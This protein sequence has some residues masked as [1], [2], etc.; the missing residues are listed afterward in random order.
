M[1]FVSNFNTLSFRLI[2]VIISLMLAVGLTILIPAMSV[3]HKREMENRMRELVYLAEL[4]ILESEAGM[5]LT[6][7][8]PGC[9]IAVLSTEGKERW[10]GHPDTVALVEG[11]TPRAWDDRFPAQMALALSALAGAETSPALISIK[12]KMLTREG[13]H[14]RLKMHEKLHLA[15]PPNAMTKALYRFLFTGV[16]LVIM[17]AVLIGVPFAMVLQW[18]VMSPLRSMIMSM[19]AFAE[20]PYR[21][22]DHAHSV[23]FDGIMS[24]AADALN[25][26]ATTAR[27]ELVQRDKL[28][29]LGEAIAKINHD[30]RNVLSSAVLLSD[31]L[32]NSSDPHVSKAAPVVS[33]AIQ[34]AT[35]M[36]GQILSFLKSPGNARQMPTDILKLIEEC[37]EAIGIEVDY[38]GPDELVVDA[39]QFFRLLHNLISNASSAGAN[40]VRITV[41]RV[42]NSAVMDIADNGPGIR[43]S[44][45]SELFKPFVGSTS[46]SSGLGLSIAR[47]IAVNHGGDLKLSRSNSFGCEFQLRLPLE[48]L[49]NTDRMRWWE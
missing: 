49:G 46:G 31:N 11:M 7:I 18:L 48:V 45:L 37:S 43:E 29:S 2:S 15:F 20:D 14:S 38:V 19:A 22:T 27:N 4:N 5:P 30:M 21:P 17:A 8:E 13:V 42:G 40:H 12:T 47:E 35:N 34:R 25:C 36:C 28:A 33:K 10:F 23:Q 16:V 3:Y 39:S 1:P 26:M 9:G 41:W 24:E 6:P 32:E 44:M